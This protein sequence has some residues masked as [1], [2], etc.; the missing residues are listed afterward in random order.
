MNPGRILSIAT[1]LAAFTVAGGSCELEDEERTQ[2]DFVVIPIV[3]IQTS[4]ENMTPLEGATV[5]MVATKSGGH[6]VGGSC[7]TNGSGACCIAF[8]F[9]QIG[10]AHV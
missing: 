3:T 5:T 7:I 10:R 4:G 2:Q 9:R 8:G 6:T 1:A